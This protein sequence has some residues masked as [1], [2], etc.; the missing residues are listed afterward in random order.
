MVLKT[1]IPAELAPCGVWCGACPSFQ[2][3]C[4]GCASDD[5]HQKRTSKWACKIRVCAYEK[6][7][8]DFCMNCKDFP[9]RTHLSR[10]VESHPEDP[11]FFYRH[12]VP[13]NFKKLKELGQDSYML[14]QQERYTCGKCAGKIHFYH[15]TCSQC[16][17]KHQV[18][19]DE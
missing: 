11:R 15:Y 3:T 19:H 14:Y 17:Q 13:D 5:H 9:C 18:R 7:G 6:E 12:E 10:L 16:G 2:K 8:V 4:L 1:Q